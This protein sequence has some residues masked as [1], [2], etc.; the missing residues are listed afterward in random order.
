MPIDLPNSP[1]YPIPVDFN[2]TE[3]EL[4]DAKFMGDFQS[5]PAEAFRASTTVRTFKIPYVNDHSDATAGG[6]QTIISEKLGYA[7]I[8]NST[9][10]LTRFLPEVD[11]NFRHLVA[12]RAQFWTMT[13]A[14]MDPDSD[15]V[16]L[17]PM[18]SGNQYKWAIVRVHYAAPRFKLGDRVSDISQFGE[19]P[20]KETSRF[21]FKDVRRAISYVTVKPGPFVWKAL[22]DADP[23]NPAAQ[24][25]FEIPQVQGF[26]DI[27]VYWLGIPPDGVP[28]TALEACKGKCNL[29][30][31][32]L[33]DNVPPT[34]DYPE[35]SLTLQTYDIL[36]DWFPNGDKCCHVVYH[37]KR[38]PGTG[39]TTPDNPYGWNGLIYVGQNYYAEIKRIGGD[40]LFPTTIAYDNLFVLEP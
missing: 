17:P 15:T 5:Y 13:Y 36:D 10:Q 29:N 33:P 32:T 34:E 4:A 8:D 3:N 18:Q 35:Q 27:D 25:K 6:I 16:N 14:G 37:F 31:L 21:C 30:P 38:A 2:V 39:G 9:L 40:G 1:T 23:T 12:A 20:A 24:I 22:Y 11:F 19:V 28:V 7:T 26:E